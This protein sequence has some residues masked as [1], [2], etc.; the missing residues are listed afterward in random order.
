MIAPIR[1]E[2]IIENPRD[3]PSI[4]TK[5]KSTIIMLGLRFENK[6]KNEIRRINKM[7]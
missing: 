2:K 4:F 6:K 1:T 5:N 3:T 7:K